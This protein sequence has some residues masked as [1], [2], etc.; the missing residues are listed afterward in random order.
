[1]PVI[2]VHTHMLSDQWLERIRGHGGP[3]YSVKELKGQDVIHMHDAPFMTLLPNMFDFEARI[4][5]M[6]KAGVDMAIVSL[7]CPSA[8]WGGEEVSLETSRLM[9]DHFAEQ[10]LIWPDRLRWFATLPWQYPELAAVELDRAV[11]KGAVGVF[12]SANVVGMSLTDPHLAPIWKAVDDKALPVL[13]HPG[14]P[15][16]VAEMDVQRY[17]LTASVGF[18]FDTTLAVSRMIYDGFF[19]RHKKLKIIA[20]HGGGYLPYIIGRLDFCHANMPPAREVIEQPPS[21]YVGQLYFDSVVFTQGA[22]NLCVDVAGA[23]NVMYGS[24]YPHNIGD[25]VGCLARVD[26]LPADQRDKVRGDNALRIFDI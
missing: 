11:A 7:T 15:P 23:D 3:E 21:T 18:M 5:N 22:L 8:Y 26:A 17:N 1:M 10:Q 6:D 24:D 4:A 16:G 9:N 20:S 14:A 12:V 2:D 19:D 25:M 13:I